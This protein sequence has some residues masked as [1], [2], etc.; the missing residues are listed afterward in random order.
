MDEAKHLMPLVFVSCCCDACML[1]KI[2]GRTA[3][4]L[5]AENHLAGSPTPGG[6]GLRWREREKGQFGGLCA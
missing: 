5:G 3:G 1:L 6:V 4:E 2:H